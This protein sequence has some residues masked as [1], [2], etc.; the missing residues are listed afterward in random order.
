MRRADGSI[1]LVDNFLSGSGRNMSASEELAVQLRRSGWTVFT[2][3]S[4]PGR[5][6]KAMDMV[7]T[8]WKLRKHYDAA[9]VAVYSGDAFRWAE[10]ACWMLRRAGK[11][12]LL[13]LHGGGLPNFA[14]RHRRRT[15]RLLET[16]AAVNAP[17]EYLG[18]EM[19]PYR[20]DLNVVPN[21]IDLNRVPFRLRATPGPRLVWLRSFHRLY[22]PALAVRALARLSAEFPSASLVMLGNDKGDGSL[23]ET[24]R[25]SRHLS[26]A[27]R[28]EFPGKCPKEAV[29]LWLNRGDI[30]LNTPDTDNT[31]VSV[32]EAMACGL[33]I[34]ST[35]VGGLPDLIVDREDGLLVNRGDVNGMAQAIRRILTE[36]GLAARLSSNARRKAE[37]FDWRVIRP[38]WEEMFQAI[39]QS[40]SRPQ[41][42]ERVNDVALG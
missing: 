39:S 29:P 22:N 1:L 32:I 33:C 20:P 10:A 9:N 2:A 17:S 14:A 16:A 13:T 21:A 5:L 31:P 38:K 3:S 4:V 37:R 11:P 40:G 24:R 18:R 7:G 28:V 26:V 35:N 27:G 23:Q 36:P 15:I 19:R 6:S 34:V 42:T 41:I 30:L 25:I 8:A 12:Y